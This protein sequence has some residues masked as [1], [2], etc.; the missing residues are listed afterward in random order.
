MERTAKNDHSPR[1][2]SRKKKKV[3][4]AACFGS[5]DGSWEGPSAAEKPEEEITTSPNM[6]KIF[7]RLQECRLSTP[8]EG[9][10]AISKS[11]SQSKD[12]TALKKHPTT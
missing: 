5:G 4:D 1:H 3:L 6:R 9:A 12:E 2:S 11:A 10:S 7:T 8:G